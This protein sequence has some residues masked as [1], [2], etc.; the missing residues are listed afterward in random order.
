[1][2]VDGFHDKSL[3]T[4]LLFLDIKPCGHYSADVHQ[5]VQVVQGGICAEFDTVQ[6]LEVFLELFV[7]Q[8]QVYVGCN[9]LKWSKQLARDELVRLF[10]LGVLCTILLNRHFAGDLVEKQKYA[11]FLVKLSQQPFNLEYT[12]L[13]LLVLIDSLVG[14]LMD[15][16]L[17]CD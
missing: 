13:E 9:R 3:R 2:H 15:Y 10:V 12:L 4:E 6:S 1:M 8:Q 11:V 7:F 16:C 5:V 14:R 17:E